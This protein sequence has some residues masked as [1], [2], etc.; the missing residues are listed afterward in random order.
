M[1]SSDLD[2]GQQPHISASLAKGQ[3]RD[4]LDPSTLRVLMKVFALAFCM[5]SPGAM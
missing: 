1:T 2:G 3:R 5:G 4:G